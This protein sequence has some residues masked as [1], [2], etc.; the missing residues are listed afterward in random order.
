MKEF[1]IKLDEKDIQVIGTALGE[2]AFKAAAPVIQKL[3]EQINEQVKE[4]KE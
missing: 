4:S 1:I 3:Q 2:I